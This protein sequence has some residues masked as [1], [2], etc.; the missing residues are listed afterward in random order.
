MR[1]FQIS[2]HY[3]ILEWRWIPTT[4]EMARRRPMLTDTERELFDGDEKPGR[5]YQAV[6]P[7]RRKINEEQTEDVCLLEGNHQKLPRRVERGR[8]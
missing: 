2:E 7:I 8:V 1:V 4:K 5:Y 3:H 6:S